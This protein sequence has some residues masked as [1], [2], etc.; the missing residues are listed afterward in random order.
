MSR[1]YVSQTLSQ[2]LLDAL[3]ALPVDIFTEN[4]EQPN[5]ST[6][7]RAFVVFE[8]A[9]DA[10]D[11]ISLGQ[12]FGRLS[13]GLQVGV[14]EK[15]GDGGSVTLDVMDALDAALPSRQVGSIVMGRAMNF[16]PGNVQQWNPRG[17][18][19]MFWYDDL[20]QS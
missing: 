18:Q 3:A 9:F 16:K 13:G 11:Q 7:T 4:G 15:A 20:P 8:I 2:A 5:F 17:V 1:Q 19:Y 6:Q 12:S 10:R 14:F